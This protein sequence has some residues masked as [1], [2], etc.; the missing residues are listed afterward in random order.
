MPIRAEQAAKVSALAWADTRDEKAHR[1]GGR[2]LLSRRH[3]RGHYQDDRG[4]PRT[5]RMHL[6]FSFPETDRGV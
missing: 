1:V 6:R 3:T 4:T 5:R 2:R